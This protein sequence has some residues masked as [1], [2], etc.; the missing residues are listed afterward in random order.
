MLLGSPLAPPA[1]GIRE[2]VLL[3]T[4]RFTCGPEKFI[5]AKSHC[6]RKLLAAEAEGTWGRQSLPIHD[7]H[8]RKELRERSQEPARKKF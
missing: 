4:F 6:P 8:Q 7:H 1:T 5:L 3:S 2:N